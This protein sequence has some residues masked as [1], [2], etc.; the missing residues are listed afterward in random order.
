[1]EELRVKLNIAYS[2]WDKWYSVT[3]AEFGKCGG[4]V[5][6]SMYNSSLSKALM[7]IYSEH[8]WDLSK[9]SKLPHKYWAN[10]SNQRAFMNEIGLKLGINP[11]EYSKWYKVGNADVISHGG[12][13]ILHEHNSSLS[14]LLNA[15][16]SDH[17]WDVLKF[18]TRPKFFWNSIENQKAFMTHLGKT[19][20]IKEGDYEGWYKVTVKDIVGNGGKGILVYH[21]G[22]PSSLIAELFPEHDWKIWKFSSI[23]GRKSKETLRKAVKFVEEK[24]AVATLKDW[25][26]VTDEVLKDLELKGFI[27]ANGGILKV[28]RTVYPEEEWK[29][30][31]FPK[32][33]RSKSDSEIVKENK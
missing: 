4:R 21:N 20:G 15:V 14:G 12:A 29:A 22:S 9:F 3:T 25:Y 30:E 1:M 26:R 17:T 18:E 11:G 32:A 33:K 31:F 2:D 27:D 19:L 6:L 5:L 23:R 7:A 8:K 28:L 24:A 16:Y 10:S 13:V